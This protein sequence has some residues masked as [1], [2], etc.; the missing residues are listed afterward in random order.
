MRVPVVGDSFAQGD[1]GQGARL[2]EGSR[3]SGNKEHGR[4]GPRAATCVLR[5][6]ALRIPVEGVLGEGVIVAEGNALQREDLNKLFYSHKSIERAKR[7]RSCT[8][9]VCE[10][11]LMIVGMTHLETTAF[12]VDSSCFKESG[13]KDQAR[14]L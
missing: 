11:K 14:E 7:M 6:V 4:P 5:E 9:S 10:L 13:A 3:I 1:R 2:F 12:N 8:I